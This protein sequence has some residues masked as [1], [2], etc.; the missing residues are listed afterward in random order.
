MSVGVNKKAAFF[1]G[2]AKG[3]SRTL[4]G[5][6]HLQ[7]AQVM[8]L[9]NIL[10]KH[11]H[12]LLTGTCASDARLSSVVLFQQFGTIGTFALDARENTQHSEALCSA[13]S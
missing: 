12:T 10:H 2:A 3:V 5:G 1:N 11:L 8:S 6:V 4:P 9:K 13:T 7:V